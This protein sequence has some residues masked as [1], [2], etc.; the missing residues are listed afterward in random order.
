MDISWLGHGV[1]LGSS[2]DPVSD[3]NNMYVCMVEPSTL[4]K[5]SNYMRETKFLYFEVLLACL[6]T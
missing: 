5:Y 1:G 6:Y 2:A 3:Q 4:H